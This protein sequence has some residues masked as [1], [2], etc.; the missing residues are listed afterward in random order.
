MPSASVIAVLVACVAV[1]VMVTVTPGSTAPLVSVT[2]PLSSAVDNCADAAAAVKE[3]SARRNTRP[4]EN[5]PF[6]LPWCPARPT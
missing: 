4:E 2:R 3:V 1:W 6:N 5:G